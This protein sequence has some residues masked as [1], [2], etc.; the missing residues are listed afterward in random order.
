MLAGALS[1]ALLLGVPLARGQEPKAEAPQPEVEEPKV[2]PAA[3]VAEHAREVQALLGEI[4]ARAEP[5]AAV[6][7]IVEGLPS[8]RERTAER[9]PVAL[10]RIASEPSETILFNIESLHLRE[11]APESVQG[12]LI[13]TMILRPVDHR[14]RFPFI[15]GMGR[16]ILQD[17]A[18]G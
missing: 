16:V 9:A 12:D 13:L 3:E 17:E 5:F 11:N 7:A 2:I 10:E 1:A 6:A 4:E 14:N 8:V 18:L 15:N